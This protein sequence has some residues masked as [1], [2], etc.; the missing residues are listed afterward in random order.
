MSL[1]SKFEEFL[2]PQNNSINTTFSKIEE[3]IGN[4]QTLLLTIKNGS[5]TEALGNYK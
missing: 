5:Q 3:I 2:N 4:Y 1:Y